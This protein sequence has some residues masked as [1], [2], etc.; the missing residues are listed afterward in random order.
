MALDEASGLAGR[1]TD[2]EWNG[3]KVAAA[4]VVIG[5]GGTTVVVLVDLIGIDDDDKVVELVFVVVGNS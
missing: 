3:M 4:E 5:G 2:T 1:S